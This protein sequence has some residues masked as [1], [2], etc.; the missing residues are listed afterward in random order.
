MKAVC[1][2]SEEHRGRVLWDAT[3]RGL[4]GPVGPPRTNV[5]VAQGWCLST[6]V[7]LAL[8]PP[9]DRTQNGW[10]ARA[11]PPTHQGIWRP[12][13][14]GLGPTA[15]ESNPKRQGGM[16]TRCPTNPSGLGPGPRAPLGLSSPSPNWSKF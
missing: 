11:V 10:D 8:G 1:A 12:P 4:C 15:W 6:Q 9:L 13:R 16:R 5:R 3:S 7:R 2:G 14:A